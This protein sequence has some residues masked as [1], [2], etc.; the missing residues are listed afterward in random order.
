MMNAEGNKIKIQK[1]SS[2]QQKDPTLY[3]TATR[4]LLPPYKIR[5]PIPSPTH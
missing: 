4:P 3:F 5:E 2:S 1:I